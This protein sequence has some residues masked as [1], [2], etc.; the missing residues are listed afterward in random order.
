MSYSEPSI[1]EVTPEPAPPQEVATP[2]PAANPW[3][4]EAFACETFDVYESVRQRKM[5][6][7]RV[8]Y[9]ARYKR[10]RYRMSRAD[11]RRVYDLNRMV[12]TEMGFDPNLV[13][14]HASH[15]SSGKPQAIHILNQ[16][17]DANQRS[18]EKYSYSRDKEHRIEMRMTELSAQGREY[19]RARESLR[20]VQMYKGN[21][22]WDTYLKFT[23]HIP[24]RPPVPEESWDESRSVWW[25]G[26]GLYGMNAVLYTHVWDSQAPP[27]I[28]C[29][30]D[31]IIATITYVWVA[32]DAFSKCEELSN[33]DPEKY[34]SNGGNNRGI[35]RRMAKGKCGKGKLGPKWK[36]LMKEFSRTRGV[37]WDAKAQVG[38]RFPA[39]ELY[40]NGKPKRDERGYKIPTDRKRVFDHM[41][42]KARARGLL[43]D[44]PLER[45]EGAAPRLIRRRG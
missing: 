25:F 39:Y 41:V 12:A 45:P 29:S 15:E 43:N 18:W 42:K 34:G 9:P 17:R 4:Q 22:H 5:K 13:E 28:M 21:G 30:Y 23:R 11:V 37:D 31:G 1:V 27:W 36:G 16:D 8:V 20:H 38:D 14:I 19:W 10:N 33:K 44:E 3:A 40:S 35:I 26:Y 32:R 24:E 6:S 7:G 2:E